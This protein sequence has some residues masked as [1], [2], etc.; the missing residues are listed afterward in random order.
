MQSEAPRPDGGHGYPGLRMRGDL[1]GTEDGL[2][3]Y[4]YVRE[5]RRIRAERTVLEQ[6]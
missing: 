2:A 4:P 6:D 3:K 5:S 1:M